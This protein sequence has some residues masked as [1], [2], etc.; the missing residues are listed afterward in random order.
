M[1]IPRTVF[2]I[3]AGASKEV[4]LPIGDELRNEI[5]KLMD[6]NS[7]PNDDNKFLINTA[8]REKSKQKPEEYVD[9]RIAICNGLRLTASIDNYLNL[10]RENPK[11][12]FCGK[13]AIINS[14]LKAEKESMLFIEKN[15]RINIEAIENTWFTLFF[16]KLSEG[17]QFHELENRLEAITF[18]AFNYD[19]CI[20]HFLYHAIQQCYNVKEEQVKE[21]L[22]SKLD[23]YHPYGTVGSL[24]WLDIENQIEFGGKTNTQDL[25]N[26]TN[27][28]RTF[29]ESE[30]TKSHLANK[31]DDLKLKIANSKRIIF[32][33][34]SFLKQNMDLI[35]PINEQNKPSAT[36][37][38]AT[39]I[40]ISHYDIQLIQGD[41]QARFGA[42]ID[43]RRLLRQTCAESFQEFNRAFSF[44]SN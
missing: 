15:S 19:R 40:G 23:I 42:D 37:I 36:K 14:I 7:N 1:K 29:T 6:I 28:I 4:G 41:L 24:P 30:E 27:A 25:V 32:L 17:C 39:T 44:V 9:A 26:L 35:Y 5:I 21:L 43:R 13:L 8:I 11:I 20:E 34:F 33:G 38:F 2:V 18:I 12:V 22:R 10:H 16:R 31:I 3:G